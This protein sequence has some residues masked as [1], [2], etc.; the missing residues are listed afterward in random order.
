MEQAGLLETLAERHGQPGAMNWLAH[1]LAKPVFGEK[2]PYLVLIVRV[3]TTI[4]PLHAEDVHAAVLLFE[5][6]LLGLPTQTFSTDDW[7]GFRTV[8]APEAERGAVAFMAADALFDRGAQIVVISYGNPLQSKRKF[9]PVLRAG[10][11]WALQCR[12]RLMALPLEPTFKATLAKLGKSTRFNLGYYRRRLEAVVPCEFVADVRGLIHERELKALN[13]GCL[14]PISLSEFRRQYESCCK[15]PGGYL[16]GLRSAQGQWL[17]LIGGWR[18]ADAT[19]LCWQ[20][21]TAGFEK[22]SLST[23]M[24]SFYLE[25]EIGRGAKTLIIYGGTGHSMVHSFLREEVTDLLVERQSWR[26]SALHFVA[27]MLSSSLSPIV[28]HSLL[29]QTIVNKKLEWDS[30]EKQALAQNQ[31]VPISKL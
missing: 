4:F 28:V 25:H 23:A 11:R 22:L 1:F 31:K 2:K 20:M 10:T 15:L 9:D 27:K 12:D 7:G 26:V 3:G 14:N 13:A 17:S 8:V 18:Q 6:R 19:V 29:M 24:R 30:V 5:Y 16:V 21:N